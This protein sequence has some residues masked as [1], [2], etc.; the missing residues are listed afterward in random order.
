MTMIM[1]YIQKLVHL[2]Q[3]VKKERCIQKINGWKGT[4]AQELSI[5]YKG[6]VLE[7]KTGLP[8]RIQ[9]PQKRH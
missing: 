5:T 8:D 6:I 9:I 7:M 3:C 4:N 2:L 1:E